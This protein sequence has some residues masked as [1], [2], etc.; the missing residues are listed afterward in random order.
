MDRPVALVE[1]LRA[2]RADVPLRTDELSAGWANSLQTSATGRAQD[3]FFLH[4]FLARRADHALLGL[5]QEALLRELTLVRLTEGLLRSN[6][7]IKEQ[8]E[9]VQ[10]DH[11]EAGEIRKELVLGPLLRVANGPE[12]HREVD[13]E[14][15][16]TRQ[17][18]RQLDEWVADDRRPELVEIR[19]LARLQCV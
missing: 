16:Q 15:V 12:D 2:E 8:P 9:D 3:E 1:V 18:N 6:D 17:P 11:H 10:D 4:A 19:H 14:D 13:R 5:G 7:Q